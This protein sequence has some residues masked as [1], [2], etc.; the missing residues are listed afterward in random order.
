MTAG[1]QRHAPC[2]ARQCAQ[3]PDQ[4]KELAQLS[5]E[6]K[7][8]CESQTVLEQGFAKKAFV[9]KARRGREYSPARAAKKEAAVEKASAAKNEAAAQSAATGD[10]WSRSGAQDLGLLAMRPSALIQAGITKGSLADGLIPRKPSAAT[11]LNP[12]RHGAT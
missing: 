11:R 7:L 2:A 6:Q 8:A 9:E 1:P 10:A 3:D 12:P 4:F 5:L